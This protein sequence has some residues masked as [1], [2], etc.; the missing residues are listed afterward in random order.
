LAAMLSALPVPKN[1]SIS[2]GCAPCRRP[3]SG[4]EMPRNTPVAD[5]RSD[6]GRT[7]P[8]SSASHPTS[9]GFE[10]GDAEKDRV[11]LVDPVDETAQADLRGQILGQVAVLPAPLGDWSDGVDSV[12]QQAPVGLWSVGAGKAAAHADDRNRFVSLAGRAC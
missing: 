4:V 2:S 6:E 3:Y 10:L 12:L 7:S 5:P 8:S 9:N 11:E 1:A